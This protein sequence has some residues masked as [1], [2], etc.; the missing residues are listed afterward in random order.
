MINLSKYIKTACVIAAL[1]LVVGTASAVP[2]GT[3]KL[4]NAQVVNNQITGYVIN[5]GSAT[6]NLSPTVSG[7]PSPVEPTLSS[8]APSYTVDANQK[9]SFQV[10]YINTAKLG[11]CVF[12]FSPRLNGWQIAAS[13]LGNAQCGVSANND[14]QIKAS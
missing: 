9:D 2:I 10:T 8:S 4:V 12:T 3:L 13:S 6:V 14:L 5:G 11:G 1:A 7:F